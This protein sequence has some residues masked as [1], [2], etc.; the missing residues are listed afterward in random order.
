MNSNNI[1]IEYPVIAKDFNDLLKIISLNLVFDKN[2]TTEY[3]QSLSSGEILLAELDG[4][5]VGALVHRR[6]GKIFFE[7]PDEHFDLEHINYSKKDLGY[8]AIVVVDSK[9]QGKGIGKLL[10]NEALNLQKDFGSKAVIVHCWQSSPG[11]GSEK[12]F[13]S[14]GF[15]ALKVHKQPWHEY[16]LEVGSEGHL[17]AA[18][19]NPCT[20]DEL[21][22]IKYL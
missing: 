2:M 12:L 6:P 10:L 1:Q 9:H 20:C 22:M 17:C 13:R 11:K 21:E 15:E 4:K 5:I 7:L 18:C 19:G 16:A 14:A 3:F 8:I